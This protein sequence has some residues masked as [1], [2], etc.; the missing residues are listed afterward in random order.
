MITNLAMPGNL[1]EYEVNGHIPPNDLSP[2]HMKEE[3]AAAQGMEAHAGP[4]NMGDKSDE[5]MLRR[6]L[7][8]FRFNPE[9]K[10]CLVTLVVPHKLAKGGEVYRLEIWATRAKPQD[11]RDK[12][13]KEVMEALRRG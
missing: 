2:I 4:F 13:D 10:Y 11:Y 7:S 3:W 5:A 8:D 9:R 12:S 1:S 6:F